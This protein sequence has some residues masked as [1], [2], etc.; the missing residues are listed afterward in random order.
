[1]ALPA[2][3]AQ[4]GFQLLREAAQSS[5]SPQQPPYRNDAL[6]SSFTGHKLCLV[7]SRFKIQD[8]R[9]VIFQ[10]HWNRQGYQLV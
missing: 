2:G 8:C 7:Q 1:M 4:L 3:V 10:F 6:L 9:A 5:S